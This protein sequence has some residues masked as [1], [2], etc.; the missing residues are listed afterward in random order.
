[1]YNNISRQ[2]CSRKSIKKKKKKKFTRIIKYLLVVEEFQQYHIV[3]WRLH[4]VAVWYLQL[5]PCQHLVYT[6]S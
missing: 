2:N 6:T 1:M 4:R 3:R 5:R